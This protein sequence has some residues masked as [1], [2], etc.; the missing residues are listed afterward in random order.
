MLVSALHSESC[1]DYYRID[2][3]RTSELKMSDDSEISIKIGSFAGEN[4]S[5][6][7]NYSDIIRGKKC[8]IIKIAC[9]DLGF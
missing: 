9:E 5:F 4:S 3:G 6:S 1:S 2:T 8:K 7:E